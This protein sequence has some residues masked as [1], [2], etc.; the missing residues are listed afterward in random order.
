MRSVFRR[1]SRVTGSDEGRDRVNYDRVLGQV[2]DA[3]TARWVDIYRRRTFLG[4]SHHAAI[5]MADSAIL[6]ARVG[7]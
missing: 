4:A 7:R 1:V 5:E 2:S 3:E 6:S